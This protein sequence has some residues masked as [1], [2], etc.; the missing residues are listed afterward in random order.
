MRHSLD[1][2]PFMMPLIARALQRYQTALSFGLI[3]YS[4]AANAYGVW[5][6]WVYHA[7]TVVPRM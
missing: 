1:F 3:A 4:I 2:T 7:F 5:F 6:S